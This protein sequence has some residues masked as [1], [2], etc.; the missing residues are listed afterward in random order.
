M[1]VLVLT[2]AKGLCVISTLADDPVEPADQR[3]LIGPAQ[4]LTG[5][6][7]LSYDMSPIE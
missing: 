2:A 1:E 7:S 3:Q 4:V 6:D 5:L